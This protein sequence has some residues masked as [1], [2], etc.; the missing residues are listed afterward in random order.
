[1][2]KHANYSGA[3]TVEF[4]LDKNKNYYF[5]E[6]NTRIQV[7][8]PVTEMVT[9]RDLIKMQIKI[10]AGETIGLR[11]KDIKLTGTAIE[12]RINAED[13]ARDFAPCP[14]TISKFIAPG[15]FGVRVDTH[16][17][18]GSVV[19]PYYDSMIS[20]LIVHQSNREEA[21]NTM[22]RALREFKIEPIKTTI[23]ACLEI[24]NH[25][26]YVKNKV[27]TGF[28]ERSLG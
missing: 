15:G 5:I 17:C 11:Q 12:C 19:S 14:G 16:I 25:N 26:L 23:P 6:V 2:I 28:I 21:I 9:G 8:H 22:K 1:L 3:A 4:L 7:E 27:D 24:L 13:P 18:Q 20:K 10:A